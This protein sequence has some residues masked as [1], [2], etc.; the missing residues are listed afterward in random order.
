M[1]KMEKKKMMEKML[2]ELEDI[3][4]SQTSLLKKI[5]QLEAENINL[6]N[7]VL[8]KRLPDIHGKVDEGIAEISVV[9]EEFTAFKNKF[10]TDNKL[11]EAAPE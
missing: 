10:V 2:R 4:N 11:D 7:P 3:L 8:E 6:G 5:S 1:D 9:M